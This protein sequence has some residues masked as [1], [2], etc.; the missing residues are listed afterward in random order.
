MCCYLAWSRKRLPDGGGGGGGGEPGGGAGEGRAAAGPAPGLDRVRAPY[1]A[2]IHNS[3]FL[4]G[5]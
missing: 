5:C 4:V 1:T 3:D 2:A